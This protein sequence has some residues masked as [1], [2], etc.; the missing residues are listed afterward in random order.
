LDDEE[1]GEEEEKEDARVR[2]VRDK[3]RGEEWRALRIAEP[4]LPV[5]FF[6]GRKGVSWLVGWD[7]SL[8]CMREGKATGRE[9]YRVDL[10]RRWRPC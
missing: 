4:M 2:A 8:T 10:H 9:L 3:F 6:F 7:Q 1:G 5:A